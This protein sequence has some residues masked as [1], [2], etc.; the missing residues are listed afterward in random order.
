MSGDATTHLW[1]ILERLAEK[2]SD[3]LDALL[4][5]IAQ[6]SAIKSG[7]ILNTDDMRSL[8]Q[9]L[10]RCPDPHTSPTEQSTFIHMSAQELEREFT[11]SN[12]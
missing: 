7:Q 10:E 9:K 1:Q 8:I 11:R 3:I 5:T 12:K 2:P 6:R 4:I